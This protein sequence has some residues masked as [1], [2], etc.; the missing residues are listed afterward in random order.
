MVIIYVLFTV[1]IYLIGSAVGYT[2]GLRTTERE[3]KNIVD[4]KDARLCIIKDDLDDTKEAYRNLM[5]KYHA[6]LKRANERYIEQVMAWRRSQ[7][8][9]R[10]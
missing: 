8:R 9:K 7:T 5:K 6:A 10:G 1:A 4:S 3:Y 2:Q